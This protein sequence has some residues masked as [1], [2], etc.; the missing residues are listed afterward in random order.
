[1]EVEQ[2]GCEADQLPPCS[3]EMKDEWSG[4]ATAHCAVVSSKG[5]ALLSYIYGVISNF[6]SVSFVACLHFHFT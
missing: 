3:A 5:T 1:M 4:T 2:P 6:R